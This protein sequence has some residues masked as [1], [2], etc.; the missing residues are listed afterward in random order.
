MMEPKRLLEGE[1]SALERQLLTAAR[2]DV[3]TPALE[4][5]MRAGLGLPAIG[6][7]SAGP[8]SSTGPASSVPSNPSTPPPALAPVVTQHASNVLWLK[9]VGVAALVGVGAATLW[10]VSR[11][12][13][14]SEAPSAAPVAPRQSA[15]PSEAALAEA[16]EVADVTDAAGNEPESEPEGAKPVSSPRPAARSAALE[17]SSR[18][19]RLR[20]EIS[21]I[22][23][24]RA[25]LA[26]DDTALALSRYRAYSSRFKDGT[27]REEAEA[28]RVE[29]TRRS[30]DEKRADA[31]AKRFES[32]HPESP[33][34]GRV[35]GAASASAKSPAPQVAPK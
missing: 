27:L 7:P 24:M 28:L 35:R 12:G 17:I 8:A 4:N 19:A 21:L 3:P 14:A 18:E 23:A 34:L 5:V 26:K 1:G 9:V 33:H 15:A 11:S 30:G 10:G 25:A 13:D 31:L 6:L 2:R 16:V 20:E 29:A 22:D 32:Q